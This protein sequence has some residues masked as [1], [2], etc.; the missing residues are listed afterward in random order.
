MIDKTAYK[1]R[2]FTIEWYYDDRDKSEALEYFLSLTDRRK[3]KILHLFRVMGDFGKI[4]SE[5]KFRNE[6]NQIYAFKPTPDRFLCFFYTGA[7]II[8][9]NGFEKKTE[10][11][12]SR[13]KSRALRHMNNYLNR[14]H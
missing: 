11:L 10:K 14:R 12:P 6:G 13:E 9:T 7:K 1:G 5:E 2:K 3:D 4:I 8:V